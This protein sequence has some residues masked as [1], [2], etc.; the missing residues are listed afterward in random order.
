MNYEWLV[1]PPVLVVLTLLFYWVF[2]YSHRLEQTGYVG[3]LLKQTLYSAERQKRASEVD[4]AWNRGQYH[5]NAIGDE[6]WLAAHAL[7][8]RPEDADSHAIDIAIQQLKRN[9]K[10]GTLPPGIVS[11]HDKQTRDYLWALRN[12][13][14]TELERKAK[15]LRSEAIHDAEEEAK[16]ESDRALGVLDFSTVMGRGPEF[17]LQFTAVVTIVFVVLALGLT[18]KLASQ[19]SGTILAAIAGYVLGQSASRREPREK[20]P[21]TSPPESRKQNIR[22]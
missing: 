5:Q 2:I 3:P 17:I 21:G 15:S 7:P 19:Q 16:K 20:T 8:E 1:V 11:D 9:G 12:W 14:D 22:G 13:A 6:A 18:G 4:E 10:V